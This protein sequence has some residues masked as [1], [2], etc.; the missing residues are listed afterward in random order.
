MER[1][2]NDV[3]P[4]SLATDEEVERVKEVVART[5]LKGLCFSKNSF[6]EDA[7]LPS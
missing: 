5:R 3:E 4:K 2:L 1:V 6:P 7:L